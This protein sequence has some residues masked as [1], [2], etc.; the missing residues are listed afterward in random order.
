M[1]MNNEFTITKYTGST[2]NGKKIVSI[3][4]PDIDKHVA[5]IKELAEELKSF[6]MYLEVS[7]NT[8]NSSVTERVVVNQSLDIKYDDDVYLGEIGSSLYGDTLL[9]HM[10]L[11][12]LNVSKY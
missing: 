3:T 2:L 5:R 9:C 7:I 12:G 11:A 1:L 10:E 8:H 6:E 4:I